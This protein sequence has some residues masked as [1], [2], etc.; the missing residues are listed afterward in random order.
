MVPIAAVDLRPTNGWCGAVAAIDLCYPNDR[1]VPF[2]ASHDSVFSVS[3]GENRRS[4]SVPQR[5]L[6]AQKRHWG[7]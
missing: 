1:S 3:F 6:C 4:D 5:R 2:S 7:L